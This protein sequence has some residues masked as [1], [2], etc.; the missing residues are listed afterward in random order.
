MTNNAWYLDKD[1][2][3][4]EL[5]SSKPCCKICLAENHALPACCCTH[6]IEVCDLELRN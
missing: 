5:K 4:V 6:A 2:K 1:N 3:R